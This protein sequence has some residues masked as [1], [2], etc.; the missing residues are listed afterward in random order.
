MPARRYWGCKIE[1]CDRKHKA[2]GY[3]KLH[4]RRLK[5]HGSTDVPQKWHK[6]KCTLEYCNRK[7][8]VK[9]FCELHYKR[10]KKFGDPELNCMPLKETFHEKYEIITE[11]GCWIWM[12]ATSNGYGVASDNGKTQPAHRYSWE[13]H[14][15][16]IP[17]GMQVCHKCDV[18]PCVNPDHLFIGTQ[19]DNMHDAMRKGRVDYK[20]MSLKGNRI[21]AERRLK[22]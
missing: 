22:T 21:Q 20:G 8:H 5:K 4:Y 11:T 6:G 17:E 10:I 3:C 15:G 18:K 2:F 13:L 1:G 16:P 14:N 9:G 12:G 7:H 19:K